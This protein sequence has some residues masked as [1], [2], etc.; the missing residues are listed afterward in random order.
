MFSFTQERDVTIVDPL[1]SLNN[2][3]KLKRQRRVSPH[4][5]TRWYSLV[6]S[7]IQLGLD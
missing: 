5:N 7:S 6:W 1:G 3:M 2:L 4:Q